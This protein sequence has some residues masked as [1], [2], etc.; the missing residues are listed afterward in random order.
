MGALPQLYAATA[1]D[2]QGGEFY[3]PGGFLHRAGYP[4]KVLSS[5]RSYDETLAQQLWAL[6]EDLTG[7]TYE[8]LL[9]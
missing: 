8:A 1:P 7:V 9:V 5:R 6:S 3:A 2:V 4:K